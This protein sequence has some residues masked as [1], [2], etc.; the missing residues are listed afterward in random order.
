[1]S[2]VQAGADC[3]TWR[4]APSEK[5]MRTFFSGGSLSG[6][7]GELANTMKIGIARRNPL[8]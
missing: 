7:Q 3:F 8:W 6:V 1:V 4:L 2:K 5:P